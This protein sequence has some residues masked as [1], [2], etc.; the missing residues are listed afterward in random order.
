MVTELPGSLPTLAVPPASPPVEPAPPISASSALPK[1]PAAPAVGTPAPAFPVPE[2]D[3]L[4]GA[5]PDVMPAIKLPPPA[6]KAPEPA[7]APTP[8]PAP[9]PTVTPG[10]VPPAKP[11]V[12]PGPA[13][14]AIDP[15][16]D[17]I[18][19]PPLADPEASKPGSASLSRRRPAGFAS[20][21]V[22]AP[23][24]KSRDPAVKQAASPAAVAEPTAVRSQVPARTV[25]EAGQ[26]AARVGDDVIT[27][28][29]LKVAM[30]QRRKSLPIDQPLSRDETMMLARSVLNDLIDRSVVLQEAKHDLKDAK[31]LK[32][33]MDIADKIW[34]QEEMPPMLQ[35][36]SSANIY[37]LKRKM[38]EQ[39]ESLDEVREQFRL[40]F[41][42]QG[43]LEQKLSPR[44]KVDLL[45]MREYYSTHLKDFDRPAQVTWRE[46]LIEIDA[47]KTRA[48][49][50]R[51]ADIL[52]ARLRRGEDFATVART[53]SEGPNKSSG[54]LW[55]TA[56]GSY[57]VPAVNAALESLPLGQASQVLEGPTSYHIV[58]VEARRS[59]GPA[60]FAEVQKKIW[61]ILRQGKVERESTAYLDKLRKRTIIINQFEDPNVIRASGER[62]TP[63]P[64]R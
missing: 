38:A 31:N 63:A 17:P 37:E 12:A 56:P 30:A 39:G 36:T 10:V 5:N 15:L 9:A 24:D 55:Q 45:E 1:P 48:E 64:G 32:K 23:T 33:V 49:A 52:L 27:I 60:P 40:K 54:G 14:R 57:S 61:G 19:L 34:L 41:V 21:P 20:V 58:V 35:R 53:G 25:F 29:E 51:K 42:S 26:A 18:E 28:H 43:Y 50:R 4:L 8:T 13:R 46:V 59:A 6:A 44:M 62:V 47:S 2:R 3:P 7:V 16:A 11:P 22:S